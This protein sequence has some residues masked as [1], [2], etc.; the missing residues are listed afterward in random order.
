MFK[1]K[2][3]ILI[4]AVLGIFL[5]AGTARHVSAAPQ[6]SV[7]DHHTLAVKSDG[8]LWA[9]GYNGYGALGDGTTTQRNAPVQIGTD[10]MWV[11]VSGGRFYTL[12]VKSDG[13]LW[14]WGNN[15]GNAPVQIGTDTKWVSVSAGAN[16]KLAVKSDGTLWAWGFNMYGQLGDGT[17][18]D[19]YA[20]VQIGTDTK[21]VSVS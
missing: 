1:R 8:T 11:S 16:H 5:F 3:V 2:L 19:K 15:I 9:W 10:T 4:A 20:P 18:T 14:A 7:G 13:T 17:N 6:I 12:A 21:W